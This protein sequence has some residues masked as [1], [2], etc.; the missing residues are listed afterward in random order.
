MLGVLHPRPSC[1]TALDG[2][3]VGDSCSPRAENWEEQWESCEGTGNMWN[4]R[5]VWGIRYRYVEGHTGNNYMG[6]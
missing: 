6:M 5:K 4:G 2:K 3:A 1:Q